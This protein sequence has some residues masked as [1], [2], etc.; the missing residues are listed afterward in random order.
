L[1][2]SSLIGSTNGLC[3]LFWTGRKKAAQ[4]ALKTLLPIVVW[5]QLLIRIRTHADIAA[6]YGFEIVLKPLPS[7][8]C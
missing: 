8:D 2:I 3:R 1:P 4:L 7:L 5:K 6:Q